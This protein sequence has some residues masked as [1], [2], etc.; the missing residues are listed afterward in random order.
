M[1]WNMKFEISSIENEN[2]L[3]SINWYWNRDLYCNNALCYE[4]WHWSAP[5]G[6]AQNGLLSSSA[7]WTQNGI[8][9]SSS[10]TVSVRTRS[11]ADF[12]FDFVWNNLSSNLC[13][14][15]ILHGRLSD[16]SSTSA[17][18]GML[19]YTQSS[20]L[21]KVE[22]NATCASS[23]CLTEPLGNERFPVF[24]HDLGMSMRRAD[25]SERAYAAKMILHIVIST[26]I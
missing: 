26:K 22:V 18:T 5:P 24:M 16:E 1:S 7:H 4:I 14:S 25:T 15:P 9:I 17:F 10:S 13:T 23:A 21:P 12:S 3:H 2:W 20:M 19:E 6:I 8:G 11:D